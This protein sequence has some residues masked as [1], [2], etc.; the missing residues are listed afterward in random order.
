MKYCHKCKKKNTLVC[1]PCE[2]GNLWED[3]G[4]SF[5]LIISGVMFGCGMGGIVAALYVHL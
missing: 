2:D 5:S 3:S 1:E 4:N